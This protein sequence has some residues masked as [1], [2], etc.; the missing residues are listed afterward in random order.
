M[1]KGIAV[2][3]IGWVICGT[4][5]AFATAGS[6]ENVRVARMQIV[7]AYGNFVF[8][9]LSAAP[10][11]RSACATNTYWHFTLSLDDVAGK[12]MY[13]QLLAAFAAGALLNISGNDTCSEFGTIESIGGLGVNDGT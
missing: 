9:H 3:L 2:F 4:S 8:V 10:T 11:T 13:A 1:K 12:N 6:A 5:A 7:R